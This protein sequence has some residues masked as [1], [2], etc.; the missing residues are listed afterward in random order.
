MSAAQLSDYL[1]G[2]EHDDEEYENFEFEWSDEEFED[3]LDEEYYSNLYR[4]VSKLRKSAE[5]RESQGDRSEEEEVEGIEWRKKSVDVMLKSNP[6]IHS[7]SFGK[8]V[9]LKQ[10][11]EILRKNW[12]KEELY[13]DEE[14]DEE[15]EEELPKQPKKETKKVEKLVLS[16]EDLKKCFICLE[17]FEPGDAENI[18]T[19]QNCGHRFCRECLG[20]YIAFKSSDSSCL[21][22]QITLTHR[23]KKEVIRLE[24]LNAY[25]IPCPA[26]SCFH[27]MLINELVPVATTHAIDRFLRFS[28]VHREEL[29]QRNAQRNAEPDLHVCPS[30]GDYRKMMR[31]RYGRLKCTTCGVVVCP[32]CLQYHSRSQYCDNHPDI[33][34]LASM[35]KMNKSNKCPTCRIPIEKDGGCNHMTCRCGTEFCNICGSKLDPMTY[36]NH[37][38]NGVFGARCHGKKNKKK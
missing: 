35:T 16:E 6:K 11:L 18:V 34:Q 33:G 30:C 17:D 19:V 28:E 29:A 27:V 5:L 26:H 32:Y 23:E 21:Y 10:S 36:W 37:F 4:S 31:I 14:S 15:E 1:L 12:G 22:H 38:V 20:Q 8:D 9:G 7:A 3:E 25:G 24:S 2:I 13:S